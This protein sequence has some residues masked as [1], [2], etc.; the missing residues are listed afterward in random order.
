MEHIG[1]DVHKKESQI[2]ILAEGGE[3][4]ERRIPT[5][6]RRFAEELGARPHARILLES[7]TESEW[8]ARCLE[9]LGHKVVVADPNFAPMYATRTRKVK[10]DRRDA[11]ALAE[12]CLLGAYRVAHRLSDAQRHVRARLT[13]RDTLVRTRTRYISLVR[14]LLRQHGWPVPTGSAEGFGRRVMTLPLPGRLRSEVAPLLAVM[15]HLQ[16]QLAYSD[17]RIAAV[18]QTDERVRRLQSV[19]NIGPVTA[20]AFVAALD[21]AARFRRAHEV[22]AY[23]G[24]VP[25]ELSSGETQRRGRIT[26]AGSSRV[27]WLLIQAA[28]S[29][30]RLH[31]PRTAT[32]REWAGRIA[33]RRGKGIAVVALARRLAGI[34]FALLR[35]GTV[36]ESRQRALAAVPQAVPA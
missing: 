16:Q 36:Y 26:K 30:R 21:D 15:R 25:R 11:R 1:I 31:D 18:T 10:T 32:L 3:L 12:A 29:M 35:D 4:M 8:V 22:E 20:A 27:R 13:V 19:P 28:V 33:A 9:G 17:E 24:L 7:S 5:Q 6:P 14:A 34:L 2:C 23:L